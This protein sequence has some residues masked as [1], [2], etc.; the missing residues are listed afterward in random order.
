MKKY[1]FL[2]VI[3][4]LVILN[5][6]SQSPHF[7]IYDTANDI[8][9]PITEM[10]TNAIADDFGPTRWSK[11][12]TSIEYF[13]NFIKSKMRSQLNTATVNEF[14]VSYQQMLLCY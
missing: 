12:V 14:F 1:I 7:R 9:G 10:P 8:L 6:F 5:M 3:L 13:M 4:C 11:S 2:C